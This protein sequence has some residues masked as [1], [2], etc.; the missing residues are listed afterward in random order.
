MIF[1]EYYQQMINNLYE[2]CLAKYSVN[3]IYHLSD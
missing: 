3:L 1:T 2:Q